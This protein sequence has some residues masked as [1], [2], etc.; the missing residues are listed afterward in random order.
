MKQSTAV[1]NWISPLSGSIVLMGVLGLIFGFAIPLLFGLSKALLLCMVAGGSAVV[2]AVVSGLGTRLFVMSLA[3]FLPMNLDIHFLNEN[4]RVSLSSLTALFLWSVWL[5][6]RASAN[7]PHFRFNASISIPALAFMGATG[8]SLFANGSVLISMARIFEPICDFLLFLYLVNALR[9]EDSIREAVYALLLGALF[10]C[11]LAIFELGT[12][13]ELTLMFSH[14]SGDV[15]RG[16][17]QHARISGLTEHANVLGIFLGAVVVMLISLMF[18][19]ERRLERIAYGL[20]IVLAL[21]VIVNTFSRSAWAVI[22]VFAPA[23]FMLNLWKL[24]SLMKVLLPTAIAASVVMIVVMSTSLS[25]KIADRMDVD[26]SVL[27]RL[28]MIEIG[29]DM[30][31]ANPVFGVGLNNYHVR[32]Y[33]HDNTDIAITSIFPGT[34][35]NVYVLIASEGGLLGLGAFIWFNLAILVHGRRYIT[36][37]IGF[38]SAVGLSCW[39]WIGM[40]LVFGMANPFPRYSYIYVPLGILVA[41]SN[42]MAS[43]KSTESRIARE[44]S[45]ANFE[46]LGGSVR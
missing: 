27:S 9:S 4:L 15:W 40:L 31:E 16:G 23:V 8:L 35:H 19:Q 42:I 14:A 38:L 24:Q 7:P 21:F 11:G 13:R 2:F 44:L 25:S 46:P 3:F 39:C 30:L 37:R 5:L 12:G 43:S 28:Y 41:V 45:N 18:S 33:E 36:A 17:L 20:G 32:M 22:V 34:L 10:Q 1:Q 29:I 6:E 26:L